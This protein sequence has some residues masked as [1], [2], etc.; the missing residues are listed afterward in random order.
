MN[1]PK[2]P[3][4]KWP[5]ATIDKLTPQAQLILAH[6]HKAGSITH[7]EALMDHSVQSLTRRI[8]ELNDAGVP[9]PRVNLKHPITGQRYCRYLYASP[10]PFTPN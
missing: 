4:T 1:T 2:N 6:M 9:V 10:L 8:T 5:Q 3:R 7:R